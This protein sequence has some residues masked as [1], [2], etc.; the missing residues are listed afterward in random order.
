[1][2]RAH[3]QRAHHEQQREQDDAAEDGR[4][5]EAHDVVLLKA[6]AEQA[7]RCVGARI[8]GLLEAHGDDFDGIAPLGVE[9]R[10]AL[11]QALDAGEIVG[12]AFVPG[13]FAVGPRGEHA[14]DH[15]GEGK[16]GDLR[17]LAQHRVHGFADFIIGGFFRALLRAAGL[18]GGAGIGVGQVVGDADGFFAFGAA[19][20]VVHRLRAAHH[21]LIRIVSFR[22]FR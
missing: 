8:V 11:H 9:P 12:G 3:G 20:V 21:L 2:L 5:R 13:G 6:Q 19:L 15:D 14:I 10:G 7:V 16:A 18:A 22:W 1:M 4:L 17:L